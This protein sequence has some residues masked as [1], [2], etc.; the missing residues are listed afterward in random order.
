MKAISTNILQS[1]TK[2]KIIL[3]LLLFSSNIIYSQSVKKTVVNKKELYSGYYLAVEPEGDS[4]AG[5][6][7]LLA[8]FGQHAEDIFPETK[9][10]NVAY[11]N[12]ILTI[13]FAGG[14]KLYADSITQINL[15][16]VLNDILDKYKVD[17]KK[18]VI[19][20]FSAGGMI[21]LRYVELCNEFP[22]KFPIKPKGVFMVDSPIDIFTIWDELE[23]NAKNNY[24]PYAVEEAER[25]MKLI[26]SDH[27]VPRENIGF[28]SQ[29]NPFNMDTKYGENEKYLLN[30]AV[31]A[32]H[33]VDIAWRLINRN[34]TVRESN[35]YVTSELINRLLLMGN[36]KAEFMQSF[37]TG[38]RSNGQRHPHSWSIV[39]E[40]ECIQW[41]KGLWQ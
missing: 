37:K 3:L 22:D 36:K 27:G 21:A 7:V 14:N 25:A 35:Y 39:N 13:A 41:I 9:L 23:A 34:Q 6:L 11:S 26:T 32:Y 12:H 19:G 38:Y 29:L 5:V 16:A 30:T 33:D 31:R 2:A 28:Y 20:G 24:S 17:S 40:V 10:Q 8:G 18:F 4:I 15:T 1:I